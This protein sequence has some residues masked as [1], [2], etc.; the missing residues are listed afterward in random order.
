M[1][2]LFTMGTQG[3]AMVLQVTTGKCSGGHITF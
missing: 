3:I 2:F 1:I